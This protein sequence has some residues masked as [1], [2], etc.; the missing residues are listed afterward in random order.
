MLVVIESSYV[1]IKAIGE[2]KEAFKLIIAAKDK[3]INQ[4]WDEL[5]KKDDQYTKTLKEEA[6]DIKILVSKMRDQ[7][8][9]L[10]DQSIK[11]LDEIQKTFED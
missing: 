6:N 10:R 7:Y 4:F 11:E 1:L 8:F 9:A 2:Q 5:K 3:L